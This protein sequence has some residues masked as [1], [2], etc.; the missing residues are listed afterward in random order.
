[1]VDPVILISFVFL[2]LVLIIFLRLLEGIPFLYVFFRLRK[3]VVISLPEDYG[4]EFEIIDFDVGEES[5]KAWFFKG[6]KRSSSC[7]LLIPDFSSSNFLGNSLRT[8]GI[9]QTMDFNVILPQIH[10]FDLSSRKMVKKII[11]P[12]DYQSIINSVYNYILEYTTIDKRKIAIYS[13]S[14]GT[15]FAC[16]LVKK[17]HLKAVVLESGPVTLSSLIT[18]KIPFSNILASLVSILVRIFMWPVIWRTRWNSQRSLKML[19]SCPSLQIAVFHHNSIP[20]RTIFQNYTSSYKP[21]QLWI[22]DALLPVGGIRNT[23]VM[24]YF[25]QINHFYDRWLNNKQTLDWHTEMRVKRNEK[26]SYE[27]NLKISVLPPV[28]EHLPLRVTLLDGKNNL[29]HERIVFI[30]AEMIYEFNTDF[31]PKIVSILQYHNV[32]L[33]DLKSWVKQDVTKA[34][35]RN[36]ETM[37]YLNLKKVMKYEKR[38][39][40]IKT[41]ILKNAN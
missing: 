28:L 37:T 36:I 11:S 16:S 8:A 25:Y 32:D 15:V 21:K 26:T 7:I 34:L 20:N 40:M 13:D 12:R 18:G 1:L 24:E 17:H 35:E 9:L 23:W 6:V 38:Y 39:F 30:G 22:E 41:A 4:L 5:H 10:E 2:A 27:V 3:E 31:R 14:L 19:S 29:Q 33:L